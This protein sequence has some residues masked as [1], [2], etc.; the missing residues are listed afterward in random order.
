MRTLIVLYALLAS[1]CSFPIKSKTELKVHAAQPIAWHTDSTFD[2]R[3]GPKGSI[4]LQ[5]GSVASPLLTNR[6]VCFKNL[7][8]ENWDGWGIPKD[9]EIAAL[10]YWA[11]YGE[12]IYAVR[13]G[14][15][16]E[17]YHREVEEQVTPPRFKLI[18][19]INTTLELANETS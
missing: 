16:I 12:V 10:G 2:E 9:A 8:R 5:L 13:V 14:D 17:V 3:S 19:R 18:K 4:S 1:S 6:P 7:N 15:M 11:G